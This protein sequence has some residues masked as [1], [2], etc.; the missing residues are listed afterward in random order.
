MQKDIEAIAA[1]VKTSQDAID[2]IDE[3]KRIYVIDDVLEQSVLDE[4]EEEG[5]IV[6]VSESPFDY[7][8]AICHDVTGIDAH[9]G[10]FQIGHIKQFSA[11]Q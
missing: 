10:R 1:I 3:E 7:C 8:S 5:C 2:C 9:W 4:L 6:D 11:M